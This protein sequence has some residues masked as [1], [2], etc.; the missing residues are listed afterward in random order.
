M[1]EMTET[2]GFRMAYNNGTVA[3]RMYPD[4][5]DRVNC[6]NRFADAPGVPMIG[7]DVVSGCTDPDHEHTDDGEPQAF[8]F[9]LTPAEAIKLANDLATARAHRG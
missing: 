7:V 3:V 5:P 1:T 9:W 4:Q 8:H 2:T 6:V